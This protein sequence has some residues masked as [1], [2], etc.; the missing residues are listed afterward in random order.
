[1]ALKQLWPAV[2]PIMTASIG[3]SEW[4]IDQYNCLK[5]PR[6]SLALSSA[7]LQVMSWSEIEMKKNRLRTML[8]A[9]KILSL[10]NGFL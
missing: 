4:F 5:I 7:M 8:S 3:A 6:D 10:L 1:M 9:R 2:F